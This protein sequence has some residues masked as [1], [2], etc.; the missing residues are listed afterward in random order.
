M[1]TTGWFGFGFSLTG[2][3]KHADVITMWVKDG[4]TFLQVSGSKTKPC[5]QIYSLNVF[6][7]SLDYVTNNAPKRPEP[8]LESY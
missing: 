7:G 8:K 2:G 4:A 5:D 1:T 3:M 6:A